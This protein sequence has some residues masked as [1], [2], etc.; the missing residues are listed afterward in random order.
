L[1]ADRGHQRRETFA[2]D[3]FPGDLGVPVARALLGVAVDRTQQ[4]VDIDERPSI[5]TGQ[6]IYAL[7]Q[8]GQVLTQN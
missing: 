7:A 1:G 5:G 3:L 8:G 4:R 6:Q 2:Q